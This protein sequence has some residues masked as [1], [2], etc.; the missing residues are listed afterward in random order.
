MESRSIIKSFLGK[1]DEAFDVVRR[2]L[3]EE[4]QSNISPLGVDD[5]VVFGRFIFLRG[6]FIDLNSSRKVD[7]GSGY[8]LSAVVE[9]S[10]F[11]L[12]RGI[13][14]G[15]PSCL[16]DKNSLHEKIKTI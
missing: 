8:D 9:K 16:I 10:S 1:F 7:I 3:R 12:H 13:Q 14:E 4:L 6:S 15:V 5:S 2:N 11:P